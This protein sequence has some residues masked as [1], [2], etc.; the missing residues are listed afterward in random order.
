VSATQTEL[1]GIERP[2]ENGSTALMQSINRAIFDPTFDAAKLAVLLDV[3]L[4]YEADEARKAYITAMQQF[5]AHPP[6]I[7]KTK[8][9]AFPNRDGSRTEYDHA[10]LPIIAEKIA[11]GLRAVGIT[12]AWR[13]SDANGRTTVTC[14]LTHCMGHS[15]DAATL[16]GPPDTSGG[17][18][19]IQAIGSTV[20]YLQRYTLLAAT[21]LAATGMDNDGRTEG[22]PEDAIVDY[23]IQLQ[24]ASDM[25]ELK[26][27]FADG[28]E[29][30]KKANDNSAKERIRK[31]YEQR[32]KELRHAD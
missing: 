13:C 6:E 25:E 3:K 2:A 12:H 27:Y 32:K 10:E 7:N 21:G 23:C 9:V 24:D 29:K 22:M 19:S 30:A 26:R 5:K 20:T 8:H 17:K 28:W 18:N 31:V 15:E 14:V 11:E 4:K 1:P 16:S